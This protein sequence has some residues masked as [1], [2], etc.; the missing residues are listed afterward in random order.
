M[1][2]FFVFLAFAVNEPPRWEA[3]LD[4]RGGNPTH[5]TQHTTSKDHPE[6][7]EGQEDKKTGQEQTPH[8]P[9]SPHP[10]PDGITSARKFYIAIL[11]LNGEVETGYLNPENGFSRDERKQVDTYLEVGI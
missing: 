1:A 6:A 3:T 7:Q 4:G 2:F 10:P 9:P 11:V 5:N 8:D